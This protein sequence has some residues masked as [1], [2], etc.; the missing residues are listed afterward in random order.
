MPPL[1]IAED[2]RALAEMYIDLTLAFC[3]TTVPAGRNVEINANLALVAVGAM[4]GHAEGKGMNASQLARRIKMPRKSVA[5]RLDVLVDNGL[6]K[7]ID[8]RYFLEPRRAQ[9]VPH[10]DR[11]EL[12]LS[13]AIATL[14]PRLAPG[15]NFVAPS[16][17]RA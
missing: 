7:R 11:F 12:I 14:A 13:K 16:K 9:R 5:R 15:R 8:G 3:A 2:R 1:T 10:R 17:K 4:L 6:L